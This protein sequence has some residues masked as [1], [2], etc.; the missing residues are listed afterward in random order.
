MNLK[1]AMKERHKVSHYLPSPLTKGDRKL[2]KDRIAQ[3]NEQYQLSI[4]LVTGSSDGLNLLSKLIFAKNVQNYF[5]LAGPNQKDLDEKLGYVGSELMLFAQVHGLNTWWI[6]GMYDEKGA[7]KHLSKE[8]DVI[9]GIIVVGYGED[10]GKPHP[11]KEVRDISTY[12]GEIPEWFNDGVEAVLLAPSALNQ[13]PFKIFGKGNSVKIDCGNGAFAKIHLGIAKHHF[14][15]GAGSEH[16]QW[17]E[18]S[19]TFLL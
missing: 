7:K 3:L 2:L 18:P 14:E 12:Q 4:T 10:Q 11:S 17:E 16:F 19:N 15:L 9:R 13:Q 1:E 5:I 6:G 8:T